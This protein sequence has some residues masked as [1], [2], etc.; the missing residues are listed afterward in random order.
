VGG[1]GGLGCKKREKKTGGK[2]SNIS[3][4]G[5]AGRVWGTQDVLKGARQS[6]ST[7]TLGLKGKSILLVQ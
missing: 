4:H 1:G 6:R 5:G 3:S 7:T 2:K